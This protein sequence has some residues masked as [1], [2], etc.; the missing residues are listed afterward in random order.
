V[1]GGYKPAGKDI[2]SV[3]VGYYN[4]FWTRPVRR[5]GPH[6]NAIRLA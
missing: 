4:F 3:L 6:L 1:I 5:A 2:D